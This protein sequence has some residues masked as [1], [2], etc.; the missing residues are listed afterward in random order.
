MPGK[1]NRSQQF[2]V[3]F[4][5]SLSSI[6][7]NFEPMNAIL[8]QQAEEKRPVARYL[9]PLLA[10]LAACRSPSAEVPAP[11]QQA[12]SGCGD[13]AKLETTLFGGIETAVSWSG[14]EMLC[15][16]MRRPDGEGVRLRFAGDAGGER[17]ALIIALPELSPGEEA[18]DSPS[19]VTAIVEGSGRFFSTPDLNACWTEIESQRTLP[20][21]E[22]SYALS[23]ILSCISPLGQVNGDA[24]VS[25]PSLSFTTIVD[26]SEM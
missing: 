20:D 23:G 1:T 12:E 21:S 8:L 2:F 17:L 3:N 6:D 26:W 18:V 19:N 15:E 24:A 10:V 4:P 16:S 5:V 22:D 7:P 11:Q 14:S 13:A 25:I 9:L